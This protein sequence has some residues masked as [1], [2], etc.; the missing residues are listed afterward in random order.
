M[1]ATW[2]VQGK[3]KPG[4]SELVVLWWL[5]REKQLRLGEEIPVN[6][7]FEDTLDIPIVEAIGGVAFREFLRWAVKAIRVL[8]ITSKAMFNCRSPWRFRPC[9]V[10]LPGEVDRG[11]IAAR[12]ANA[13]WL[14]ILPWRESQTS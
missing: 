11:D 9:L 10:V 12:E 6:V 4:A 3:G 14:L 1:I 8:L 7:A 5:S 2:V 13:A